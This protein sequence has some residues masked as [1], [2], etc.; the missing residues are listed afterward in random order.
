[1]V[2]I[3]KNQQN[4]PPV[5]SPEEEL[6]F[7]SVAEAC[8]ISEQT[9]LD[10]AAMQEP[11]PQYSED[12]WKK[13][14]AVAE[15][16][17][18]ERTPLQAEAPDAEPE[19][20]AAAPEGQKAKS[21]KPVLFKVKQKR[22]L[23]IAIAIAIIASI[24]IVAAAGGIK[25]LALFRDS[26]ARSLNVYYSS[27]DDAALQDAYHL[28]ELPEGYSIVNL[29]VNDTVI[30]TVY[31]SAH[32]S[33]LEPIV[34]HQY[35]ISPSALYLDQEELSEETIEIQGVNGNCYS[36]DGK[37]VIVWEMDGKTFELVSRLP[38]DELEHIANSIRQ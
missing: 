20:E 18:R 7:K 19:Q 6:L 31:G 3:K 27:D 15:R 37:T 22:L 35:N 33:S 8:A 2:D 30:E 34:L 4:T 1:M 25:F 12:F 24:P 9:E 13:M 17:N 29:S 26:N 5:D 11:E 36:S 16:L 32:D 14:N 10:M 28:S 23:A 38:I 21:K